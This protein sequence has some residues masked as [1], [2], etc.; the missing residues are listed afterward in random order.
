MYILSQLHPGNQFLF[1]PHPP[2][3]IFS[4]WVGVD[5]DPCVTKEHLMESSPGVRYSI[6]PTKSGT[7][8]AKVGRDLGYSISF[9]SV[10]SPL[11]PGDKNLH[12][13]RFSKMFTLQRPGYHTENQITVLSGLF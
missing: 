1:Y 12:P 9:L 10:A 2:P 6:S 5:C 3:P 7:S 8:W 13:P 11:L 4:E